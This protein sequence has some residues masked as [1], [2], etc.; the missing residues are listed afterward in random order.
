MRNPEDLSLLKSA[1][2]FCG[3]PRVTIYGTTYNIEGCET[4]AT[5]IHLSYH[6]IPVPYIFY[7]VMQESLLPISPGLLPVMETKPAAAAT[8]GHTFLVD[9]KGMGDSAQAQAPQFCTKHV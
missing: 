9:R 5:D 8:T 1:A 3:G 6:S 4:K 7:F 2:R